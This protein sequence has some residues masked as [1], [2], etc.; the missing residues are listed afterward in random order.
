MH[1]SSTTRP[2]VLLVVDAGL[3]RGRGP[4]FRLLGMLRPLAERLELRVLTLGEPGPELTARL[5]HCAVGWRSAPHRLEGWTLV[6]A[7]EAAACAEA[8]VAA[9]A[10]E[11][12]VLSWELWDLV[13]PL[14]RIASEHGAAFAVVL[15]AIPLLN[16]PATPSGDYQADLD[17]R[18]EHI[19]PPTIRSY[20]AS[21]RAEIADTLAAIGV[22]AV[23]RTVA[24]MVRAY[25]PNVQPVVI[26]TSYALDADLL[27][28]PSRSPA[29]FDAAFMAKLIPDKGVFTLLDVT[30]EIVL[31]RP[32]FRCLIVGD[33][34]D[35]ETRTEFLARR[36]RR[37]LTDRVV[38]AGWLEGRAKYTAL[39]SARLFLY[40]S[41]GTDTFSIC[42][43]EALAVG[44]P[45]VCYDAPYVRETYA[46]APVTAVAPGATTALATATAAALGDP[47]ALARDGARARA[48]ARDFF[49]WDRVAAAEAEAYAT[50]LRRRGGA[51]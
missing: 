16:A 49:D 37:D 8:E 31:M 5:A 46:R 50:I 38:L 3:E 1:D 30:A 45:V 4:L 33:F 18:L 34:D 27:P 35:D 29:S 19:G 6:T 25:F 21:H 22:I 12:V 15:H 47:I 26:D 13:A 32:A 10:P 23:N 20:I 2:R 24:A 48:F 9:F 41:L 28:A 51:T 40:P 42:L 17:A 11:L 43:L 7:C 14:R 36:S 39:A 44:L